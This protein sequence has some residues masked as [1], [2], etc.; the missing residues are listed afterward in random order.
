[1]RKPSHSGI[2]S[3]RSWSG[4]NEAAAHSPR[5]PATPRAPTPRPGSGFNEAAAHSP[6][7]RAQD[8]GLREIAPSFNEAAAHSPRKRARRARDG[9]WLVPASMKPRR[10]RRG[11]K[12]NYD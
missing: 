4:F 3:S 8:F 7:K 6:R 11:N 9:H 10:I 1:P 5:K 2:R 12:Q